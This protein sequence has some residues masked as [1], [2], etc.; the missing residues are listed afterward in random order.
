MTMINR[1]LTG[2]AFGFD[3]PR[4]D[5]LQVIWDMVTNTNVDYADLIWEDFKFQIDS[6]QISAIKKELL[7][8]PRFTKFIIKHI[9]SHHNNLSK[10][11]QSFHHLMI[12]E[13]K[14]SAEYSNYLTKSKGEKLVKGRGKGLLAKKGVEVIVEKIETVRIP[15]KKHTETIIEETSQSEEVADT[16]NKESDKESMDHLKKLKD[17][18]S[19][20]I[21]EVLDRT[22]GSSSGSSLESE[23]EER[24]LTT[25]DKASL[26]KLNDEGTKIDDSKK[27]EDMKVADE[28]VGIEEP[29]KV[30]AKS[31]NYNPDVSLTDV[32]KEPVEAEVQSLVFQPRIETT[33]RNVLKMTP[34]N[35]YQPPSTST[36]SLIGYELKLKLYT[37]MQAIH[38]K[39]RKRKDVDTSS[40]KKG[41]TQSKSSKADKALTKPSTT[42][43]AAYDKELRQDD[44]AD[45]VKLVQDDD[46]ADDV[47]I[48]DDAAPNQDRSKWFKQD[49]VNAEKDQVTFDDQMVSTVDFTKFAKNRLKKDKLTKADL[50]GPTF[51]LLK[52]GFNNNIELEYNMEQCYLG[53]TDQIDWVNPEGDR[54]PYDLSKPLPLQG[55]LGHTIIPVDFFFNQDLEYLKTGNKD[56]KSAVSLIKLK[57]A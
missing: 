28:Q 36:D 19:G 37:M 11:L 27:S 22:S 15:K 52:G 1:C 7:T 41:K 54:C 55:P 20:M 48:H 29:K 21:P 39:K 12:D 24:F 26:E 57:A 25:D 33:V 18:G 40:S 38:S 8:F 31:I 13:I 50:E 6:R 42:N 51:K 49:M 9:L 17:E 10:R 34:I 3:K 47:M 35:L 53:L 16:V 4:L 56:K 46:M 43:K 23:D 32:L 2:K 44:A 14:A 5:L 45:D 30:Q